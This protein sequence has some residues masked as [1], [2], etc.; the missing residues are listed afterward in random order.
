MHVRL[1]YSGILILL[2]ALTFTACKKQKK[3]TGKEFIERDVLVGV[4]V[5]IH[6]MD[7]VTQDRRF[8]RKYD[9][10]SLD[11]LT[12]ILEKHQVTRQM[13]DTTM[14]V[15]SRH[16]ILLDEVYNDVLIKLNVMLDANNKEV[17]ASKPEE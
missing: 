17:A 3:I 1:Q 11:I 15:Y 2:L 9:T 5:D 12:P 8:N 16:P 10:D 4:L 13:F 6:L 7:G 14:L